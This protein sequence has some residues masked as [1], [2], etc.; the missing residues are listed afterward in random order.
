MWGKKAARPRS[1]AKGC[2]KKE[3]EAAWP[4]AK[5]SLADWD[6]KER[7]SAI[8]SLSPLRKDAYI[9]PKK[10]MNSSRKRRNDM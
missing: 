8:G 10:S 5:N 1:K 9:K 7:T 4:K 2:V 3:A 6:A